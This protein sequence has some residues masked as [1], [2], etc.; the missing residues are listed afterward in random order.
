MVAVKTTRD[1]QVYHQRGKP[2]TLKEIE[3]FC[4]KARQA[5]FKDD[6][7]P[8]AEGKLVHSMTL[9]RSTPVHD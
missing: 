6:A 5:G 9:S 3:E 8:W 2:M 1:V 7:L 4:V